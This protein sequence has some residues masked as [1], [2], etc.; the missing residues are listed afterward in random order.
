MNYNFITRQSFHPFDNI[1]H[2][3]FGSRVALDIKKE[4]CEI[5]Y[6]FNALHIAIR[7]EAIK[8]V[9]NVKFYDNGLAGKLTLQG[10]V[11]SFSIQG[12]NQIYLSTGA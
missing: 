10:K 2:F 1:T 5:V 6:S 12:E 3:V 8:N 7:A 4:D 11:F 9:T